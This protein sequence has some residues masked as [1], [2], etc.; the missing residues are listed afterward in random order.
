MNKAKENWIEEQ[1][2]DIDNSLN[3][4]NS[5]QSLPTGERPDQHKARANHHN[6]RQIQKESDGGTRQLKEVD[7]ILLRTLQLQNHGR[8]R[9]IECP[10]SNQKRRPP[11]PL[12]RS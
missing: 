12:C 7:R 9:G 2:Q 8:P 6:T 5:K 10:S 3:K 11:Y 1:C 4:Y